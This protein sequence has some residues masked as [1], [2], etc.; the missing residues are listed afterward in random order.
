[1]AIDYLFDKR[2][3]KSVLIT[4]IIVGVLSFLKAFLTW[5]GD[6][7]TQTIIYR[8]H[9]HPAHTIESQLRGDR[10][11]FGYRKRIVDRQRIVPFFDITKVVDTSAIDSKKWDRVDEQI[12]EIKL[13]GK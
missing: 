3:T 8:E 2:T 12:N 1:M 7:K 6:W 4:L 5:G 10:F 13:S 11:S 9:Y